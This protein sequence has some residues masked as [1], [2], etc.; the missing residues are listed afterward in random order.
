MNRHKRVNFISVVI[1]TVATILF[2]LFGHGLLRNFFA[3]PLVIVLPGYAVMAAWFPKRLTKFPGNV[4]FIITLSIAI[5]C[6]TG[7]ILHKTP[8]G[9]Q[10]NTWIASLGA[11]VL[12][13]LVIALF[14]GDFSI[15]S[16]LD[17]PVKLPLYQGLLIFCA[18]L[19]SV[20]AVY[21]AREGA[22]QQ[23]SSDVTQ[24]WML[25]GEASDAIHMGVKNLD[26]EPISYKL[27]IKDG[28]NVIEENFEL[29]PNTTWEKD[30][31]MPG[32]AT[33]EVNAYLSRL[34]QPHL[35]YRSTSLWLPHTE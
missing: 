13:N 25:P 16:P 15:T 10:T 17:R 26:A 9:I 32:S 1:V 34:N 2:A 12:V 4:L 23:Q 14:W 18:F 27:V 28:P 35:V 22:S 31:S 19:M 7:L 30:F 24:M 5:V 21:L 8:W 29:E 33:R 20:F 11:I 6:M 3:M